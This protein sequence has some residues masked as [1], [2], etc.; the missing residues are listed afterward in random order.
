MNSYDDE[1]AKW[2]QS[3]QGS[4]TSNA[5][6]KNLVAFLAIKK[7]IEGVL[8]AGHPVRAVWTHLIET[9][10]VSMRYETFL[11]YVNREVFSDSQPPS[12]AS[13]QRRVLPVPAAEMPGFKWNPV[14]KKEDLI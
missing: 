10:R 7:D 11:R 12:P 5:R 3:R 4:K 8:R 9:K 2:V 1:Y 13:R 6:S 14:P